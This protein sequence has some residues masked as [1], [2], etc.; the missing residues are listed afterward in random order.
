VKVFPPI[1]SRLSKTPKNENL[2]VNSVKDSEVGTSDAGSEVALEPGPVASPSNSDAFSEERLEDLSGVTASPDEVKETPSAQS[3]EPPS[4][5]AGLAAPGL[6]DFSES[7]V[8]Q[9]EHT[10]FLEAVEPSWV[11]VVIDDNETREALLQPNDTVRWRAKEKFL[12]TLGNAGG[13][14]VQL[15][16]KD[17]GPFGPTGEVVH[18]EI[19]G[20]LALTD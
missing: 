5:F 10:L 7:E 12:L 1:P 4:E 13:V 15:D 11:Q 17:L 20:G 6:D 19:L 3:L 2:E 18:K 16:G 9:K 14:R 8:I